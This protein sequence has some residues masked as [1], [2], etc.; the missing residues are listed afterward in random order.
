MKRRPRAYALLLALAVALSAAATLQPGVRAS[1]GEPAAPNVL[2]IVTDDQ[3]TGTALRQVMPNLRRYFLHEGRRFGNAYATTPVCCPSRVSI[4]SGRYVHNHGIETNL[5][6]DRFNEAD[7]LQR[8]LHEAGYRTGIFGK[9]LNAWP[10]SRSP[11]YFSDWA[12]MRSGYNNVDFN[13]NGLVTRVPDYSTEYIQDRAVNFLRT[14]DTLADD[15]PWLMYVTP[16]AP[17]GPF[18]TNWAHKGEWVPAW[19]PNPATEETDRT[20]KPPYVQARPGT[21]RDVLQR[22]WRKSLRSLMAVDDMV[23]RVMRVMERL[24]ESNTLAIYLSDN[25]ML[26]GEHGSMSG[27]RLPYT[28]SVQVPLFARWPRYIEARSRDRR[29]VANI[30]ITPTALAAAGLAPDPGLDG[31]SLLD[32]T[33]RRDRLL[34]E[35][36]DK[37]EGFDIPSWASLR[38]KTYQ[39]VSYRDQLD[40]QVFEEY[41]DLTSDPWQLEN[42]MVDEQ[43]LYPDPAYLDSIR[44]LLE[45]DRGCAGTT[46]DTACP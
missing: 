37:D 4:M 46:G 16:Y 38:T 13:V 17:H 23:G 21:P 45:R 34:L 29:L 3:A 25:G 39:Y 42:L 9:Y 36:W 2:I 44:A 15:Q 19:K 43:P 40:Q 6:G 30:D 20:D 31:R 28:R 8:R 1:A 27:K 35:Y 14:A 22:S 11:S 32:R 33:W 7:S 10:L 24:D 12:I 5:E 41:Y 26:W 18:G